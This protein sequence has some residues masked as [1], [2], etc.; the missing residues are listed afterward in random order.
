[1]YRMASNFHS[2]GTAMEQ[3]FVHLRTLLKIFDSEL[4]ESLQ[5]S[6]PNSDAQTYATSNDYTYLYFSYRWF[7]INFKREFAYE[8]TF[9][10]WETIW[11]AERVLSPHFYLFVALAIVETYRN[12]IIDNN[13][14][15]TDIIKFFNGNGC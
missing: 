7:L 6:I 12:V 9:A 2:T 15:F 14:E 4:Y 3:H 5:N 11:A 10:V 8:D 13:M 1:M